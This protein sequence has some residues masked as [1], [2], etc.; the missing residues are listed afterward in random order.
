MSPPRE[1]NAEPPHRS[2]P[3]AATPP[4]ILPWIAGDRIELL[5][6]PRLR[7]QLLGLSAGPRGRALH[8]RSPA[9]F[10]DAINAAA[11]ALIA[12][13]AESAQSMILGLGASDFIAKAGGLVD[14]GRRRAP[15]A[16]RDFAHLALRRTARRARRA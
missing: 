2:I 1:N 3:K 14:R 10:D 16:A 13:L 7:G 6:L 8:G 5:G 12:A 9:G 11:G 15:A 4:R